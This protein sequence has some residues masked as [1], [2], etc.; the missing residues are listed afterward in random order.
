MADQTL[1]YIKKILSID[2]DESIY[3]IGPP[4]AGGFDALFVIHEKGHQETLIKI[5]EEINVEND[6]TACVLP[7]QED[8]RGLIN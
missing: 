2:K 7:V 4:G 3:L 1:N 5:V 6:F 8:K